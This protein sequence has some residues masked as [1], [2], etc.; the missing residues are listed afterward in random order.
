M[1]KLS[2]SHRNH[3]VIRKILLFKKKKKIHNIHYTKNLNLRSSSHFDTPDPTVNFNANPIQAP[4]TFILK[5]LTHAPRPCDKNDP[6]ERIGPAVAR[7]LKKSISIYIYIYAR[8]YIYRFCSRESLSS[9]PRAAGA[10][11]KQKENNRNGGG[12]RRFAK[13][14]SLVNPFLPR[15]RAC[16]YIEVRVNK[17]RI[18]E[19]SGVRSLGGLNDLL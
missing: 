17:R 18:F 12:G 1:I 5:H 2:K 14:M 16:V 8:R 13:L 11:C 19:S 4:C 6:V 7:R 9:H 3:V 10:R 15:A